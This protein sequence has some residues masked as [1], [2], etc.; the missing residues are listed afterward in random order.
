MSITSPLASLCTVLQAICASAENNADLLRRNEAATRAA[1]I[2][3]VLRALGWNTADMRMVE[4][5]RSVEGKQILDYVLKD[6]AHHITAIIEAK[7]LDESLDKLGHVGALIGYAFS[8]KPDKLFIT[9]G[10]RWH[11]FSPA[12]SGYHPLAIINLRETSIVEAALQLVQWL[13]A[14]QSGHGL[15]TINQATPVTVKELPLINQVT[16]PVTATDKFTELTQINLLSLLP[17]QK[18]SQLQLPDGS[19]HTVKTWKDILVR[20]C[21]FVLIRNSELSIPLADRA[22]KKTVLFSE[23][24]LPKGITSTLTQYKNKPLY[25]YTNYNAK[26]CI[27]NAIYILTKLPA[28]SHHVS[29]AVLF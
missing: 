3:P 25:I 26:D 28:T 21:Q 18:P 19:F 20:C 22:G 6:N 16:K 13:D 1:L 7:K 12:H 9:D 8:L 29:P 24:P 10:L 27:A 14:A 23:N 4:P 17:N 2:D 15:S 11:F 5:E